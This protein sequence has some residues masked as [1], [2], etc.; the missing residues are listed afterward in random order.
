MA[1]GITVIYP[2]D[3]LV[4]CGCM[5]DKE[6]GGRLS[7]RSPPSGWTFLELWQR[8]YIVRFSATLGPDGREKGIAKGVDP[9]DN[10]TTPQD[11]AISLCGRPQ[12]GKRVYALCK[13]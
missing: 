9:G 4:K 3:I 11:Q 1:L 2:S 7:K 5:M 6:G 10:I 12:G 13:L 8:R